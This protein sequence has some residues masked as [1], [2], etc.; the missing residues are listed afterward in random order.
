MFL[1]FKDICRKSDSICVLLLAETKHL[2][3]RNQ[4]RIHSVSGWGAVDQL[5]TA[6]SFVFQILGHAEDV[7]FYISCC[8]VL[9]SDNFMQKFLSNKQLKGAA[10]LLPF[11]P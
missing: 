2:Y 4:A 1:T 9:T 3:G 6:F 8:C 5:S 7:K 11:C 10:K